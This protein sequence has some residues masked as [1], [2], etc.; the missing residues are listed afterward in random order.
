[1]FD[2][3]TVEKRHQNSPSSAGGMM[4]FVRKVVPMIA[5]LLDLHEIVP[6]WLNL[7]SLFGQFYLSDA[8]QHSI[9][10]MFRFQLSGNFHCTGLYS[11]G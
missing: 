3:P 2:E 11:M 1:M 7:R 4:G 9:E 5:N 8:G 10:G 6:I